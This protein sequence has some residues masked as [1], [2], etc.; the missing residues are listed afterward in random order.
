MVKKRKNNQRPDDYAKFGPIEI[1]RFGKE[2]IYR[3]DMTEDEQQEYINYLAEE[4]P[5]I[6]NRI[7]QLVKEIRDLVVMYDPL[8]LLRLSYDN[9]LSSSLEKTSEFQHNFDDVIAQRMIDYI[10]SVIVS[11][12]K[13]DNNYKKVNMEEWFTIYEKVSELYSSLIQYHACQ[14]A[15]LKKTDPNLQ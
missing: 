12:K 8:Q 5:K 11:T 6:K 10:Q 15:F 4:Y 13:R 3:N 7:D 14:T 9:L 2:I 1:A